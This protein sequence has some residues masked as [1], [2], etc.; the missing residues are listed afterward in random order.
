MMTAHKLAGR[1]PLGSAAVVREVLDFLLPLSDAYPGIDRWFL[2]KVAPMKDVTRHIVTIERHGQIVALG[3]AKNEGGE[4]KLCTIRVARAYEGR[5]MGIRVM[6]SLMHWLDTDRPL[7]TVSE[8]KMP[9]FE[10]I[11]ARNGFALTSVTN[12]LYR[13]GKLEFVF[14]EPA[15]PLMRG[16]QGL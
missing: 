10:R 2:D 16:K 5:G 15:S 9:A 13:P 11:F 6:D 4:K 12:G 14:N 7:A 8:E 3:I 1:Q